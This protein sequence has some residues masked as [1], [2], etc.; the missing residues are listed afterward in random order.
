[1]YA[2]KTNYLKSEIV[3]KTGANELRDNILANG[4]HPSVVTWSVGNEL[5][6]RPGPGAG[7]LPA[8]RGRPGQ[9][10]RPDA[11]DLLRRRRLPGRGLPDRVRAARHHRH[12][13]VL[14]L[15]PRP[16]RPDRRPH[17]AQRVPRLR[18]RL[19]SEQGDHDHRVRRRGEPQRAR[20]GEGH[21]RVP[22]GL[23]ELPPRRLRDEA[24]AERRALLDAQGVPRPA[25][26]GRR[27]PAPAAADP[28]EGASSTTTATASRRS[29]TCS[30]ATSAID[31][32]PATARRRRRC[33]AAAAR[34]PR[35]HPRP[36]WPPTRPRS[37]SPP[38]RSRARARTAACAA[39]AACPRVLYG[40]GEEPVHVQRRRPR[41]AP[42]A[43]RRPARSSSSSLDGETAN[44]VLKDSQRAPG[45][46][47]AV[48]IDFVRVRMDVAIQT[49]V[50]AR[51]R[52]RRRRARHRPRAACS[53]SSTRELNIEALP[54]DI[55][56]SIQHDVSAPGDQ[57]HGAPL[58]RHR[59]GGRHVPRRPR[60]GHRVDARCR[61]SRSR[62]ATRS[63]PRPRSS[64]RA[65]RPPRARRAEGDGAEG[66]VR[67][68]RAG[69]SGERVAPRRAL[70]PSAGV[71][72][73]STGSS[74]GWAT[75]ARATRARRTT[76]A[77]RSPRRSRAA[78]TCPAAKKKFNGLRDRGP[79]RDRRP[80]RRG[81]A[82]ADVHERG[83]A[84]RPARRAA[85]TASRTSTACSS[86]TT[87]S[88]CRS[89]TSARASAAAWPATTA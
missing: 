44:A 49:P 41:A 46:R 57:R 25:G 67:R 87:R 28:P 81:P 61:A 69:D 29:P 3:R 79:R 31:Q 62:R 58:R 1:M 82:A 86:C 36:S 51:A 65:R 59:A 11:A 80:A 73:R 56:E 8:P 9:R 74:S 47:R 76:S 52:R 24:V 21:V 88:T 33:S 30:A 84:A 6:S 26:V 83:R 37:T 2:I 20:R 71:A 63:R 10:A 32:Y 14:R 22:A 23:R 72:R 50:V 48:H 60:D 85:P 17:R 35:Y 12:Q 55:P 27:Q 34:R 77:S 40:G 68:R 19:L 43:A 42:R 75:R 39:P 66:G 18:P 89:A 38:A 16:E 64:A 7:R 5:S 13:R 4:N 15:V 78:G 70:R 53:S 54:G 45:P